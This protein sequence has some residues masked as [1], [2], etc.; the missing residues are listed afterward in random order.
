MTSFDTKQINKTLQEKLGKKSSMELPKVVMIS[1]NAG[2]GRLEGDKGAI[3][4]VSEDLSKITG[5]HAV[6]TKAKKSIS[7]FKLRENSPVGVAVT[8]RGEKMYDF[9]LK[10]I[11]ITLP[12]LRDFDGINPKS[13]D[14]QGNLSIGFKEH[15]FFP[16]IRYEDVDKSFGL[17]VNIKTSANNRQDARVL[18]ETLGLPFKKEDNNG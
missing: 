3:A 13:L 15:I 18:F 4:K 10:L 5:Q 8:L 12:R 11:N 16:E 6:V 14:E 2:V 1:V 9:L 7:A 17:Q